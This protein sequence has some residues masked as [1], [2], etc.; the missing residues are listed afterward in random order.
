M[1]RILT[2]GVSALTSF[3]ISA[4]GALLAAMTATGS[5]S[6]PSVATLIFAGLTG[7]VASARDVQKMLAPAA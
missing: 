4:G 7:A 3:V 2:I 5:A 6:V 1:N